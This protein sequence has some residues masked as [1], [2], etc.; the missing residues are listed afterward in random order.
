MKKYIFA[1]LLAGTLLLCSCSAPSNTVSEMISKIEKRTT[2]TVP[3]A[4]YAALDTESETSTVEFSS[5]PV[6]TAD[7]ESTAKQTTTPTKEDVLAA[8]AKALEGMSKEES[9]LLSEVIMQA[10]L[11]WEGQ[12]LY[13]HIFDHLADPDDMYWNIFHQTGEIQIGWSYDGAIDMDAVCSE[14]NLSDADFYEQ[15]G[16]KVIIENAYN[17][18]MFISLLSEL[19]STVKADSLKNDMQYLIDETQLAADTHDMEH[20]SN[21]FKI[22]HDLDYFLLRYGI[23]EYKNHVS[24]LSLVSKYFGTLSVYV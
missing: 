14:N 22:L 13:G 12:Y 19:R 9:T 18:D 24:D 10:N 17:A 20:A 4:P 6:E 2:D 7:S 5:T 23:D 21:M 11:W 1:G 3:P 15:F 16:T 8:R